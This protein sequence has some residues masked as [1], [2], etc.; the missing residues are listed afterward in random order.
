MEHITDIQ[1]T[2][3]L[4][5]HVEPKLR[6][7]AEQHL[8]ACE[9]CRSRYEQF[10]ET[11]DAMGQWQPTCPEVDLRQRVLARARRNAA[12]GIFAMRPRWVSVALKSAAAI[13]IAVGVGHLAGRWSRAAASPSPSIGELQQRTA[14]SLYLD[15][16]ESGTPGGLSELVLADSKP[17]G[18]VDQ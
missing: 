6:Q 8:A 10:A 16:F 14:S 13:V 9:A 3:L 7:Q 11:W 18:E 12:G 17:A 2:A 15:T 4:G 1:M 5:G